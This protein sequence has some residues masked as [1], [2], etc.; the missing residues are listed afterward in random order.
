MYGD[1]TGVRREDSLA[2]GVAVQE[3]GQV[4]F[5]DLL[6]TSIRSALLSSN[7]TM[8]TRNLSYLLR[9]IVL[10]IAVTVGCHASRPRNDNSQRNTQ[11]GFG[12]ALPVTASA[13][14]DVE[15]L[16]T[17]R[18]T[19]VPVT[20]RFAKRTFKDPQ[21]PENWHELIIGTGSDS[22]KVYAY[23]H[24]IPMSTIE[25]AERDETFRW[26]LIFGKY[27]FLANKPLTSLKSDQQLVKECKDAAP[28]F[29]QGLRDKRVMSEGV[30]IRGIHFSLKRYKKDT[31]VIIGVTSDQWNDI[32]RSI[33]RTEKHELYSLFP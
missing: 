14:E 29:Y 8:K 25:Y 18:I 27:A 28:F 17:E 9:L 4:S 32:R 13:Y 16:V 12:E 19:T 31:V 2:R 7:R 26:G 6:P 23:F 15:P 1:I 22:E 3:P 21:A 5:L 10:L 33:M 24:F 30:D 20:E 11:D